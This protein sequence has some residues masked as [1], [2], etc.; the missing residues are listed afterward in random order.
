MRRM[1]HPSPPLDVEDHAGGL[2]P[3]ADHNGLR[4]LQCSVTGF[5]ASFRLYR[6]LGPYMTA[7]AA[8]PIFDHL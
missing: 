2:I 6:A 4:H 8:D 7:Q 1:M 3:S 5:V